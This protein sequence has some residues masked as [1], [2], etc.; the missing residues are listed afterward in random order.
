VRALIAALVT[1]ALLWTLDA[2]LN[3]GKYVLA[4][5]QIISGVTGHRI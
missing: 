5:R 3:N 4:A 2:E 1:I